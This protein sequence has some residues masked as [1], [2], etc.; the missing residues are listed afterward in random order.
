VTSGCASSTGPELGLTAEN[1]LSRCPS[2]PNCVCSDATDEDHSIAPLAMSG[3]PEDAWQALM[4]YVE[5][6]PRY[7]I[8]VLADDYL[9]V[10]SRTR[11]LRF[12]DDVEFHF[13]PAAG[14]IAMRSA[15]RVGYSDLG[16]NRRRLESIRD[17]LAQ[18]GVVKQ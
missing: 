8:K 13:R 12:V 9:R 11:L 3:S 10:E 2:S 17:A 16:T 1:K 6:Q 14:E 4:S 5:A 18:A 15:S 7:K